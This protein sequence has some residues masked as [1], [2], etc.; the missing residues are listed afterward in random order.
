M[1]RGST[2]GRR[3]RGVCRGFLA[4]AG[5]LAVF[6]TPTAGRAGGT[7]EFSDLLPLLRQKPQLSG[8]LLEADELPSSA[9]AGGH[10]ER[11][12]LPVT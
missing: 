11:F 10:P 8:F 3:L 6:T 1:R 12:R 5:A 2:G 4:L 7:L 9:L